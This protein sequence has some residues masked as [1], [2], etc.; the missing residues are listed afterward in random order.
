MLLVAKDQIRMATMEEEAAADTIAKDLALTADK[1]YYQDMTGE[2]KQTPAPRRK[3]KE[4]VMPRVPQVPT[5]PLL[6]DMLEAVK[7]LEMEE[8]EDPEEEFQGDELGELA[9][10]TPPLYDDE[11]DRLAR[12]QIM[13]RG[14]Q[15]LARAFGFGAAASRPVEQ[16][17]VEKKPVERRPLALMDHS[18]SDLG[19]SA[20]K[21]SLLDDV[22]NSMG[23]PGRSQLE[24]GP[25]AASISTETENV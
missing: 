5:M 24:G 19:I 3:Q 6:G 17:P 9:P 14:T 15:E 23:S 12:E 10:R 21:R 18:E 13:T 1:K 25:P 11:E 22:P 7:A 8:R 4:S 20:Q 16:S 2:G